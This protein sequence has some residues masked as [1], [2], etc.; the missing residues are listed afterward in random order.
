M[1]EHDSRNR[2]T[3][4]SS[5]SELSPHP[6]PRAPATYPNRI[7]A[8]YL[9]RRRADLTPEEFAAYWREHHWE[10]FKGTAVCAQF[11][12]YEQMY[13]ASSTAKAWTQLFGVPVVDFDGIGLFEA[14]SFEALHE[15]LAS[16]EYKTVLLPNELKFI[17]RERS[18][19]IPLNFWT[20]FDRTNEGM[21]C[22]KGE[23]NEH[24]SEPLKE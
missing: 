11:L 6:V 10:L 2:T 15:A 4:P 9:L 17:D 3:L 20:A 12:R 18:Q 13:T 5:D 1:S 19:I 7:R 14:D 16:D 21:S 8:A 22:L 23:P 24:T